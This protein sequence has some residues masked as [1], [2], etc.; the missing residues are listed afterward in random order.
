MKLPK[1]YSQYGADMG[2]RSIYPRDLS[3]P[4]KFSLREV[5][6]DTGGYDN[7]GAYWGRSNS[8]L[9]LAEADYYY[10]EED[11]CVAEFPK[12]F[13]RAEN[14]K[15]AKKSLQNSYPNCRFYR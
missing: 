7:G 8:R 1:A 4:F 5:R 11:S 15:E 13:F 9:Y 14:R 12:I 3:L 6:L 10:K 2:R